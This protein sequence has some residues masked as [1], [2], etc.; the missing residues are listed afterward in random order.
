LI[1]V[2]QSRYVLSP[3]TA[4]IFTSELPSNFTTP[5]ATPGTNTPIPGQGNHPLHHPA[6]HG[7]NP[8]LV[9][10]TKNMMQPNAP[11]LMVPGMSSTGAATPASLDP[12]HPMASHHH[13]GYSQSPTSIKT[14]KAPEY[15][16]EWKNPSVAGME[17]ATF[18]GAQVAAKVV[19]IV[20]QGNSKGFLSRSEYNELGPSGIHDC[21]M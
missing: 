11:H 6:G 18:L 17:E 20:D 5:V 7:V 2:L 9:A 10:A 3:S 8:L 19:F 4:T 21:A 16:P 14:V 13:R 12:N 1:S 15:F